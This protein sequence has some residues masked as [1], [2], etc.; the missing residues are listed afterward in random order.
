MRSQTQY[1]TAVF[2]NSAK[3]LVGSRAHSGIVANQ[4]HLPQG[5]G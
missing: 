4:G 1:P 5:L 3:N 2:G